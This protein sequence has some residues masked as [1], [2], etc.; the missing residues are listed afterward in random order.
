[1]PW[2][3]LDALWTAFE[4]A[5]EQKLSAWQKARRWATLRGPECGPEEVRA[6]LA[7]GWLEHQ[8]PLGKNGQRPAPSGSAKTFQDQDDTLLALTGPGVVV[9]RRRLEERD[10]SQ[11]GTPVWDSAS[12][13]LSWQGE[14]VL[15]LRPDAVAQRLVLTNFQ[16][17]GWPHR[18]KEVL[19][20]S[21]VRRMGKRRLSDAIHRLT[22]HHQEGCHR[23]RFNADHHGGVCWEHRIVRE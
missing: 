13:E 7:A 12:G 20:E 3:V 1:M 2:T 8:L 11:N 4:E 18:L 14:L 10:A 23:I 17:N 21:G 15:V 16:M 5:R 22:H 19:D 9:T 6:W